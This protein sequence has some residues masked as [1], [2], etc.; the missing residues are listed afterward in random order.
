M[1]LSFIS[2]WI[3][4]YKETPSRNHFLTFTHSSLA[5]KFNWHFKKT[6]EQ[7]EYIRGYPQEPYSLTMNHFFIFFFFS[8]F[9]GGFCL[10]YPFHRWRSSSAGFHSK[11]NILRVN[12]Y[13]SVYVPWVT[14]RLK[15]CLALIHRRVNIINSD[16]S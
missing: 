1:F 15:D 7:N 6:V 9:F 14:G 16:C 3:T 5:S 11:S 8:S 4:I 13:T 2:I 12:K 10:V